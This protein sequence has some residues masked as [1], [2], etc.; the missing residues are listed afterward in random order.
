VKS[1]RMQHGEIIAGW[2]REMKHS[3]KNNSYL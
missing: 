3:G 1:T 2:L